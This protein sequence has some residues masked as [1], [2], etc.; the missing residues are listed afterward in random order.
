MNEQPNKSS[1]A[2]IVACTTI[3]VF[4][5]VILAV[6]VL[7][8]FVKA[9]ATSGDGACINRLREIDAAAKQFAL[10]HHKT[11]GEAIKFP[12]DLMPYLKLS[13]EGKIRP[14][15]QGG[16]YSIKKVGELPICSLSNAVPPH[17]LP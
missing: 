2:K 5:L 14:C 4:V 13:R 10:E 7:P 9:R 16:V 17:V 3:G 15:P 6:A 11:N 1:V 12:D 8:H